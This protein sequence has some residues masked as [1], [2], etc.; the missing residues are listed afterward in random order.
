M[1]SRDHHVEMG[2]RKQEVMGSGQSLKAA[3]VGEL[4]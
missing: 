1:L 3:G 2:G 4:L